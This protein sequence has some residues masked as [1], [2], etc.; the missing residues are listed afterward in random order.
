MASTDARRKRERDARREAIVDAAEAAFDKS[1]WDATMDEVALLADLSK[2]T[3]YLYFDDK[4]ELLIACSVRILASVNSQFD[5]IGE[6]PLNGAEMVAT[7]AEAFV[8][9]AI[10]QPKR[11]RNAMLWLFS[12]RSAGRSGEWAMIVDSLLANFERA[13][14]R[15]CADGS[16]RGDLEPVSTSMEIWSALLGAVLLQ[17]AD[18]GCLV[19]ARREVATNLALCVS[20]LLL[21]A[22]SA[23]S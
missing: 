4:E 6:L 2:G 14:V 12:R 3:L 5:A 8:D 23:R 21:T 20:K 18:L 22:V 15:G 19:E 11:F 17:T 1:G 9:H 7:M 13:L 16:L 10:S